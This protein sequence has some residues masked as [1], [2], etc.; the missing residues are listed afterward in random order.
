M[1]KRL[2]KYVG[3]VFIPL[4]LLTAVSG[5]LLLW[6]KAEIFDKGTKRLILGLHTW[7]IAAQY[8]GIIVAVG[9]LFMTLTGL[10]M[11]FS[12]RKES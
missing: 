1:L 7:E 8:V 4:F 5:G 11:L 2:H 10:L 6:R 3:I 12:S 9:L